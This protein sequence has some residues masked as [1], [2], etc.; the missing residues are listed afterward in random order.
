M[1]A[2]PKPCL[3]GT[4]VLSPGQAVPVQIEE[5]DKGR[6]CSLET[7]EKFDSSAVGPGIGY[8]GHQLS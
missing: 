7:S 5:R 6:V 1:F 4:A 3:A 2:C 8:C